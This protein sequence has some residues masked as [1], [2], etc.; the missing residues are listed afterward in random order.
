M[1]K[2]KDVAEVEE[3]TGE[4][5]DAVYE[6]LGRG[7]VDAA[8][9]VVESFPGLKVPD[10]SPIDKVALK[11]LGE[12]WSADR[13]LQER[14]ALL[15][16]SESPGV[17]ALAR[18]LIV[19]TPGFVG[20]S[21]VA[22]V[23][24][25]PRLLEED[26][27]AVVE[28]AIKRAA[29]FGYRFGPNDFEKKGEEWI[30]MVGVVAGKRHR[31]IIYAVQ[32][33]A[34]K[35]RASAGGLFARLERM[36]P[37]A[38]KFWKYPSPAWPR[39]AED[40]AVEAAEPP[41][42]TPPEIPSAAQLLAEIAEAKSS[43]APDIARLMRKLATF[44]EAASLPEVAE[45]VQAATA[46]L[47]STKM[48][49]P[50]WLAPVVEAVM[51][52][53][54]DKAMAEAL[55]GVPSLEILY[56]RLPDA[57]RRIAEHKNR[58]SIRIPDWFDSFRSCF[59]HGAHHGAGFDLATCQLAAGAPREW[60]RSLVEVHPSSVKR[61]SANE[62]YEIC[63]R[64]AAR[65]E[66]HALL[67][68]GRCE[69]AFALCEKHFAESPDDFGA[70]DSRRAGPIAGRLA[71]DSA[72]FSHALAQC[73][74]RH[75]QRRLLGLHLFAVLPILIERLLGEAAQRLQS[76]TFP[77]TLRNKA[78]MRAAIGTAVARSGRAH[79]AVFDQIPEDVLLDWDIPEAVAEG[80][81][82]GGDFD[83]LAREF[84]EAAAAHP[85]FARNA[86]A[87]S[88]WRTFVERH[89]EYEAVGWPGRRETVDWRTMIV[90]RLHGKIGGFSVADTPQRAFNWKLAETDRKDAD[91]L[92]VR[93]AERLRQVVS[94]FY[95]GLSFEDVESRFADELRPRWKKDAR[96]GLATRKPRACLPLVFACYFLCERNDDPEMRALYVRYCE[97]V[98]VSGNVANSIVL[99]E[100]A[101]MPRFK[102][103]WAAYCCV[104]IKASSASRGLHHSY[105]DFYAAVRSFVEFGEHV[106]EHV[107]RE[108]LGDPASK[109]CLDALVAAGEFADDVL[110]AFW[111]LCAP[112]ERRAEAVH[113]DPTGKH[114]H[115]LALSVVDTHPAAA[116][117]A[118]AHPP[119]R[120]AWHCADRLLDHPELRETA[121]ARLLSRIESEEAWDSRNAFAFL[122]ARPDWP[123]VRDGALLEAVRGD[124][125]RGRRKDV[126]FG[127]AI[128]G[129]L[130]MGRHGRCSKADACLAL[131]DAFQLDDPT[132]WR[133]AADAMREFRKELPHLALANPERVRELVARDPKKH[134]AIFKG[135][136]E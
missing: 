75:P 40:R 14:V 120:D 2:K 97:A 65:N 54:E 6:A 33:F 1:A 68:Q 57:R 46:L 52:R 124:F 64:T 50:G 129:I 18:H 108:L 77:R 73:F 27:N 23:D 116:E 5:R 98:L 80:I 135:L 76:P 88:A 38:K 114:G 134:G 128:D 34:E 21:L 26:K 42:E 39:P 10:F 105:G 117:H 41:S 51:Q 121:Q 29:Q 106:A 19:R 44:A 4:R 111:M 79:L 16:L 62:G 87:Y 115:I 136:V 81:G 96:E 20:D 126:R 22:V 94:A 92:S 127:T 9:R 59:S 36:S 110:W 109:E 130:L 132:A 102:P 123:A 118:I 49:R 125:W 89:V 101:S 71:S 91:S 72:L 131:E 55:A 25:F 99:R 53:I 17:V 83:T 15:L 84:E 30:N 104:E 28:A 63:W 37:A 70:I 35:Y 78:A 31:E 12:L 74:A 47:K 8:V 45:A 93:W 58:A 7:D 112:P 82:A 103:W 66:L 56:A 60:R 48:P 67:E 119:A 61:A 86:P 95:A 24:G 122:F 107:V 90:E 69:D 32:Q 133:K 11:K 113:R 13:S 100:L 85:W 3:W 43:A